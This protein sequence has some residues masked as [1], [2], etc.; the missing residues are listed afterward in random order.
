MEAEIQR[1]RAHPKEDEWGRLL[2]LNPRMNTTSNFKLSGAKRKNREA[3][4]L[5]VKKQWGCALCQV[6]TTCENTL[7]AHLEGKKH[8]AKEASIA[9][10]SISR[11]EPLLSSEK[12]S[13]PQPKKNGALPL[14]GASASGPKNKK[15]PP[16]KGAS[17]LQTND[18]SASGPKNKK[19][20]SLKGTSGGGPGKRFWCPVCKVRCNS[21]KMLESHRTGK[22]HMIFMESMKDSNSFANKNSGDTGAQG[23]VKE[24]AEAGAE[25][26][27]DGE[28]LGTGDGN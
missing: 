1:S 13:H 28:Q 27:T 7:K 19:Q 6:H 4:P 14:K 2:T 24:V 18:T 25:G 16:V 21:E 20:P 23:F 17:I 11:K 12:A 3:S 10:M 9:S 5:W 8:K 26:L 15:L 22:K